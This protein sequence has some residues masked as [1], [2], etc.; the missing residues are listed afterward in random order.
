M[1]QLNRVFQML[2]LR[3]ILEENSCSHYPYDGVV[4]IIN[5]SKTNNL[6]ILLRKLRMFSEKIIYIINFYLF[7]SLLGNKIVKILFELNIVKVTI[8]CTKRRT[9]ITSCYNRFI[10]KVINHVTSF[11][12][13]VTFKR[14]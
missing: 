6:E 13:H 14:Y 7:D 12:T 1:T 9:L 3:Y 10:G 11:A 4:K 8:V 2:F 5:R